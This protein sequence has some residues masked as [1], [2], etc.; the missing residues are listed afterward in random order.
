MI[1]SSQSQ[2]CGKCGAALSNDAPDGLC[3]GCLFESA[4]AVGGAVEGER[5]RHG[6]LFVFKDYEVLEEI[7]RG[8]MGVVYRARQ[9]SLNR[10]VAIKM[11]LSRHLANAD[12][13]QRFRAEAAIAAQLQ[14][15]NIV[16]IYEIGEHAGQPFFSMDLIEGRNLAQV[17]RDNPLPW[18][19]AAAYL[20]TIAE[21]VHYAHS[22]GVLH[23]DLKPSNV[24]VDESGQLRITDFGIAKRFDD[25]QLSTSDPQ[26]TQ[27][28]QLLGSP[29]FIPPEQAAGQKDAIG[30]ASDVYSLGAIL[31]QLITARPPLL[32]ETMTQ[33]LRMVAETEP[34]P[35]GL[36][37]A[38][39]P[40]DLETI[41]LKC[42]QKEP[43]RRYATAQELAEDLDHLLHDKPIL[44]RPVGRIGRLWRW[45]RRNRALATTGAAVILLLLAVA[46]GAPI[47]A[48]KLNRE[49]LRSQQV[50]SF[51]KDMFTS[52][53]QSALG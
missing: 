20:K 53:G 18:R 39:V 37:N 35:P 16:T 21:A 10:M 47:A 40:R 30:P 44:A 22:R 27:T 36:L 50:A 2:H 13:L 12:G 32:A 49:R 17:V 38:S 1:E 42:L 52:F 11:L 14:H 7:A 8:G 23:R 24:M 41:C 28:G 51:L 48:F 31:Y 4:F 3:A 25:A 29:S 19:T 33:T 15:P 6:A 43:Q 45:A 46:V 26:L 34:V 5:A 9:V